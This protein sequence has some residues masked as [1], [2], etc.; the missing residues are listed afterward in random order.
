MAVRDPEKIPFSGHAVDLGQ[1][2]KVRPFVSVKPGET[3]TLMD[4]AGPGVIQHTVPANAKTS[5]QLPS[6]P[7]PSPTSAL[8]SPLSPLKFTRNL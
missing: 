1:G 7:H 8:P 2:W 6:P 4:V 3:V 5:S